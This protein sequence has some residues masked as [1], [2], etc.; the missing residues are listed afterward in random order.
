MLIGFALAAAVQL[1]ITQLFGSLFETVPLSLPTIGKM[2][3]VSFG[4]IAVSEIAKL[5]YLLLFKK[6]NKRSLKLSYMS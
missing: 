1:L 2:L 5:V 3:L 6:R 4:V